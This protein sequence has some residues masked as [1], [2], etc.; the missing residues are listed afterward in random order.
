MAKRPQQRDSGR[1]TPQRAMK[2]LGVTGAKAAADRTF[3]TEFLPDLRGKLALQKFQEMRENDPV[4]GAI[5][6]AIEMKLRGVPWRAEPADDTPAARE[7]ADFVE[8]VFEDMESSW[9]DAQTN[10]LT[11][12]PYGWSVLEPV[13]KRRGGPRQTDPSR[14]SRYSDGRIGLRTLSPRPQ[15]SL[16]EWA[17]DGDDLLGMIQA[18]LGRGQRIF[19]PTERML[20]FRTASVY[21]SPNGRSILRN[22]FKPYYFASQIESV[23]AIAIDRE[24]NGMPMARI[25]SEYLSSDAT[26]DQTAFVDQLKNI[27]VNLRRNEQAS[28]IIP[29]D[30][31]VDEDGK[32]SNHPLVD[33]KL[34]ASEGTRDIDTDRVIKRYRQDIARTVLADFVML[35]QSDKGSF[36]LSK[37]KTDLFIESLIGYTEML[38]GP[39]NDRLL[40]TL[41]NLNGFNPDLMPR[42]R[43]GRVAPVDLEELGKYI[44]DLA[45]AGFPLFPNGPLQEYLA[46]QAGLPPDGMDDEELLGVSMPPAP[47]DEEAPDGDS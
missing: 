18:P 14:R 5:L 29:S 4:V 17:F 3:Q 28:V 22:A 43:P 16:W 47:P 34:I 6:T 24:L 46:D 13:Y 38:A 31:Q 37:D 27:L 11:M 41:W 9:D 45:G 33:I 40:P 36:A 10:A 25:P 30:M 19:I 44:S 26:A 39:I 42:W 15:L 20:H 1:L 2:P 23:E 21:N 12:L 7:M 8:E 35:G 32:L